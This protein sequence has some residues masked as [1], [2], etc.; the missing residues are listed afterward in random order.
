MKPVE[1]I[2]VEK[3]QWELMKLELQEAIEALWR[4]KE[5][6]LIFNLLHSFFRKG[7]SVCKNDEDVRVAFNFEWG[8]DEFSTSSDESVEWTPFEMSLKPFNFNEK[9]SYL[10]VTSI[11]I[12]CKFSVGPD[13]QPSEKLM[14]DFVEVVMGFSCPA[15]VGQRLFNQMVNNGFVKTTLMYQLYKSF[16]LIKSMVE[17]LGIEFDSCPPYPGRGY[18]ENNVSDKVSAYYPD[19][20]KF[21]HVDGVVVENRKLMS[22]DD[23]NSILIKEKV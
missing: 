14:K 19:F 9:V 11:G 5:I 16:P 13:F 17:E 21:K 22:E 8:V 4:K 15:F 7:F 10:R 6:D 2:D 23:W 12:G 3:E 18:S 20:S 1:I